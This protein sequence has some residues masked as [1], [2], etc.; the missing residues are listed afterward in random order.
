MKLSGF[1]RQ[2]SLIHSRERRCVFTGCWCGWVLKWVI[3]TWFPYFIVHA[4]FFCVSVRTGV[5]VAALL[6]EI[7]YFPTIIFTVFKRASKSSVLLLNIPS[8]VLLNIFTNNFYCLVGEFC[9]RS[10]CQRQTY[11]NKY[12]YQWSWPQ[13]KNNS[14]CCCC[15]L[16]SRYEDFFFGGG[17]EVRRI[18]FHL[19]IFSF[20]F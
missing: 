12:M 15:W 11:V 18:I 9:Q 19:L 8:F 7:V 10:L 13:Y 4:C 1:F 6:Q 20:F 5:Q 14:R 2:Q 3:V 16:I 17:E